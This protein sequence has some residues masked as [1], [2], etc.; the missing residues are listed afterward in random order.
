LPIACCASSTPKNVAAFAGIALAI[1]GAKPGK[2]A[3]IPFALH[4][5]PTTPLNVGFP[6]A[7]CNLDFTVSTGNTG[8]HI[9]TPAVAP[10]AITAGKLNVP[11]KP[12]TGSLGVNFLFTISY[13]AKYAADPGAS[14]AS[15]IN[16]PL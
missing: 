7:L 4:N 5:D 15:V 12:V 1:A 3:L 10:A 13:A 9:A 11:G 16:V 2:K 6:G 8:S 14:L